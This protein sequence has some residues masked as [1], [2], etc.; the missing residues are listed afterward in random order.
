MPYSLWLTEDGIAIHAS[1]VRAGRGT[2]GCIGVPEGFARL[3]FD[4]AH[5]GTI[6]EIV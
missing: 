6:V 2:N 1:T 4:R 3:L 5:K